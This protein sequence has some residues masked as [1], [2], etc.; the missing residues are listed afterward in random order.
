MEVNLCNQVTFVIDSNWQLWQS[1]RSRPK[2][3]IAF[4]GQ[5]EGGLVA[6]AQQV[7]GVLFVKRNWATNV[8]ANLGVGDNA[9]HVPVFASFANLHGVWVQTHQYDDRFGLLIVLFVLPVE[10]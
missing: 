3:D 5:V 7:V 4:L 1:V 8:S 6:R 9:I 10:S 2:D